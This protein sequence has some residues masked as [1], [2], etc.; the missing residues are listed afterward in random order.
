MVVAAVFI[1]N[2]KQIE[3]VGFRLKLLTI[4]EKLFDLIKQGMN[5]VEII[6]PEKIK[7]SKKNQLNLL[8]RK[9]F[10]KND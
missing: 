10:E 5:A 6:K 9:T 3:G 1:D 4:R 2:T 7:I 8:N